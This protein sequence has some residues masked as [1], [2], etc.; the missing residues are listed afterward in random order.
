MINL[1]NENFKETVIDNTTLVIVDF[2]AN[3]CG[4]CRVISPI[5]EELDNEINGLVTIAK[6]DVDTSFGR[7]KALEYGIRNI[8]TLL[9]FKNGEVVDRQVGAVSKS[10]MQEKIN[11]LF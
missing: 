1:T 8:P 11:K 10:F 4:P 7:N 5:L 9:F 2:W 3:W 6:L